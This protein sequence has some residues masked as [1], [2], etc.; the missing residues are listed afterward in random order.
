L[1]AVQPRVLRTN[2]RGRF[3]HFWLIVL[4][5]T[6]ILA[7]CGGGPV[8]TVVVRGTNTPTPIPSALPQVATALPAGFPDN[9]LRIMMIPQ[10]LE[11]AETLKPQLENA[12]LQSTSVTVEIVFATDR[13]ELLDALCDTSSEHLTAIWADALTYSVASARRCGDAAVWLT[14]DGS[15]GETRQI[16]LSGD[17]QS[18]DVRSL[19]RNTFCRISRDDFDS[20]LL[21]VLLLEAN[22]VPVS[23]FED[24]REYPDTTSLLNAVALGECSGTGVATSTLVSWQAANPG[25]AENVE[26]VV[27]SVPIPYGVLMYPYQIPSAARLALTN[28]L[29][30]LAAVMLPT[31]TPGVLG[32]EEAGLT[33]TATP[34]A[35]NTQDAVSTSEVTP[36]ATSDATANAEATSD[37]TADTENATEEASAETT[38]EATLDVTAEATVEAA[39]TEEATLA[40]AEATLDATAEIE[41]ALT[42]EPT[43]EATAEVV[44]LVVEDTVTL[45]APFV[46]PGRLVALGA[47]DLAA[48]DAFLAS[49]GLNLSQLGQ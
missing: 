47:D 19:Q 10:N 25:A 28:E 24:V 13:L 43:Q 14:R 30:N 45:L 42:A 48:L 49:S 1:R 29:P 40:T 11:Q 6:L 8:A 36:E 34:E 4:P 26:G 27:E 15:N 39:E 20:W 22:R 44:P 32:T 31:P 33:S 37:V 2:P 21:P 38:A 17:L 46:G 9:P 7:A 12:I 5:L 3:I 16:V 41:A 23:S 18:R 35:I